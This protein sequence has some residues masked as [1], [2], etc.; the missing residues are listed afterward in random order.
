M[1]K[2]AFVF[3]GQGSQ[4]IGMLADFYEPYPQVRETFDQASAA[5]RYD[6]WKLVQ[7][8]PEE[9][10]NRTD[11]TQPAMLAAGVAVWRIW[12]AAEGRSPDFMAGHSLGEY[13]A[14]VCAGALEFVSAI[15][16]VAD[17]GRYM[18]EAVSEPEGAMAAI[19]G[20]PDDVV[21]SICEQSSEG[22]IVEAV[23]FNAP[24][25]VVIAGHTDAIHRAVS[26]A[27]EM[28]A[29]RAVFLPVSVPSHCQLMGPAAKQ[30]RQRL[31]EYMIETPS[32][33]VVNNVDVTVN[34][35]PHTICDALARQVNHPVRWVE[36]ITWLKSQGVDVLI[37]CGPGKVLTGLIRRIDKSMTV[38]P[39]SDPAGLE[40]A[41]NITA[42][43]G[44]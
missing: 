5:V 33:P 24:G 41:L 38:L 44:S 21:K 7:E 27:K 28:G 22:Q 20:L 29:K 17:R 34:E 4:T 30:L 40:K 26:K 43:D 2:L 36:T 37:E 12:C 23:N 19:L 32:I 39:I 31:S 9:K 16:L 25:Q 14:L 35:D 8:G 13:T 42:G 10:L 11:Y 6:L 3:P 1:N 15:G 18:L